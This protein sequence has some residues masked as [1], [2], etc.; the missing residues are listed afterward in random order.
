MTED[1]DD[2]TYGLLFGIRRSVRYHMHRRRFYELWNTTTVV[3][4]A[5]GGTAAVTAFVGEWTAPWVPAAA[6]ALTAVSGALDLSVGTGRRAGHHGDLAR[7]FINLEKRFARGVSLDDTEFAEVTKARL[8]IES[9]E[10]PVLRL[11]DAS[12]HFE[13]LRSLG[14]RGDR[15]QIPFLRRVTM[16]W[17]SQTAFAVRLQSRSVA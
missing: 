10:P 2:R 1:L 17:F 7:Q 4:A 12:C 14:D 13:L 3:V 8:D 6:A 5:V 15:P 16:H 11:L 9:S